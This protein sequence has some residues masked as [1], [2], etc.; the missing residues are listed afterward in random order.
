MRSVSLKCVEV[1]INK[2]IINGS[3]NNIDFCFCRFCVHKV[4]I[5]RYVLD[6]ERKIKNVSILVIVCYYYYYF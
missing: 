5:L 6:F 4:K 3:F 1:L 2:R